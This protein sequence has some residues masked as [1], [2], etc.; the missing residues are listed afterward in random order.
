[1]S[2]RRPYATSCPPR[3]GKPDRS[4]KDGIDQAAVDKFF[5]EAAAYL[6]WLDQGEKSGAAK[7]AGAD[8]AGAAAALEAVRAKIDDYFARCRLAAFD[9]RAA[10]ALN[11]AEAVLVALAPKTLT[12]DAEDIAQLPLASVAANR[13]LALGDGSNPAWAARLATFAEQVVTPLLSGGK[14]ALTEADWSTIKQRMAP[15]LAWLAAKPATIVGTLAPARLREF[16][17]GTMQKDLSALIADDLA[18]GDETQWLEQVE[19]ALLFRRDLVQLLRNY[20]NFSEFYGRRKAI[21]QAGTLFIDGRACD[22]CLPVDDAGKHASLAGLARAYL[23]YCDCTRKAGTEKRTIVA[24]VTSGETDNLMVG[25]NGVFCDRKGNDWDATVTKIVENPISVRQAF[26]SPYKSFVRMV[27]QQVAKRA[28][29]ADAEAKKKVETAAAETASADKAKADV[30]TN[31]PEPKKIDVGTVAAIGVAVA[32][33]A[34]FLTSVFGMFFGLGFWMPLGLLGLLLAISGPSMLIAWLKLRRRNV[35]PILDAN[36]WA[37]NAMAKIN[38]PFGTALTQV[39]A[40]PR[41]A[42]RDL[43]DP[44]AEKKTP[45]GLYLVLLLLVGLVALWYQGYLEPWLPEGLRVKTLFGG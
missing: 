26:W 4:G 8:A 38:I 31:K 24:A 27:E 11:P 30:G 7:V 40:L 6:A 29:A 45:W 34:T 19:K 9:S 22:L 36:G 14:A 44:F 28:S 20:V 42:K 1:M 10:G 23:L 16:L 33:L 39:A 35:G 37:V 3:G 18:A 32:G 13:S 17:G 5:T 21:F 12:A 43:R 15:H 41:G 2:R 25:R